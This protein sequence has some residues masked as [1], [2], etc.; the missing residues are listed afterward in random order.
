M[1]IC[2]PPQRHQPLA[3]GDDVSSFP[4]NRLQQ[5]SGHVLRG[6]HVLKQPLYVLQSLL[7]AGDGVGGR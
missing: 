6:D 5:K 2:Q 3:R 7:G 4:L 1:L